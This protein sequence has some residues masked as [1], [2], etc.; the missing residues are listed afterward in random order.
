M[1]ALCDVFPP[2]AM[3]WVNQTPCDVFVGEC[4]AVDYLRSTTDYAR[5]TGQPLELRVN[6]KTNC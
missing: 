4:G 6:R 5:M 2:Y 3:L 1:F